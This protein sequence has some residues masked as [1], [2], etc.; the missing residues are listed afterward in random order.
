MS[1]ALDTY[2]SGVGVHRALHLRQG[3]DGERAESV[4]RER[5]RE[6]EVMYQQEVQ[7]LRDQLAGLTAFCETGATTYDEAKQGDVSLKEV[8]RLAAEMSLTHPR[9]TR[10]LAKSY[11]TRSARASFCERASATADFTN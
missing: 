9:V 10:R 7:A 5:V 4:S 6:A 1:E 11:G 3:R 2:F 8:T